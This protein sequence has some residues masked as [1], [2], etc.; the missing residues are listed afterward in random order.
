MSLSSLHSLLDDDFDGKTILSQFLCSLCF[1]K[2]YHT[3]L[4]TITLWVVLPKSLQFTEKVTS[5]TMIIIWLL[6]PKPVVFPY[7]TIFK[8]HR[9]IMWLLSDAC[10][11]LSIK[12]FKNFQI[13]FVLCTNHL[14]ILIYLPKFQR[15]RRLLQYNIHIPH[16]LES[17]NRFFL[18]FGFFKED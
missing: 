12:F 4:A 7:N 6:K 9:K 11:L 14:T 2:H 15:I 3:G 8:L 1:P 5:T 16:E 13:Q 10:Y 18:L 17:D